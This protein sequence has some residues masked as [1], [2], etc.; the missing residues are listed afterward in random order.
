MI[1]LI[2]IRCGLIVVLAF[3]ALILSSTS[4]VSFGAPQNA[5]QA[6]DSPKAW[7]APDP[8]TI[9]LTGATSLS[10]KALLQTARDA[11]SSSPG[12]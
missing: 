9:P 6:A 5:G 4:S 3:S 8:A 10:E 1:R 11:G 12:G 2:A 7:V